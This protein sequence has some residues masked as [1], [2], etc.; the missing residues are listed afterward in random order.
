MSV[1]VAGFSCERVCV[2]VI[3]NVNKFVYFTFFS[4]S[5]AL[6]SLVSTLVWS[7]MLSVDKQRGQKK[8]KDKEEK[9]GG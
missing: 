6:A 1:C 9:K 7:T 3:F 2:F 4:S 8:G 5:F